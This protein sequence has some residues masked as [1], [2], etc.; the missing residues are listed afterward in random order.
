MLLAD[1]VIAPSCEW[2]SLLNKIVSEEHIL[3]LRNCINTKKYLF[4][5]QKPPDLKV[6]NVLFIGSV[7]PRKGAFDLIKAID[8]LKAEQ[9]D[10]HAWFV[11][12]EQREGDLK[13]AESCLDDLKIK[14]KCELLGTVIGE[15]KLQLLSEADIFVLPTYTEGLPLAIGEALAA[16]LPIIST[17]VGGIPEVI[18]DGYNG[19]LIQPGDLHGLSKRIDTLAKNRQLRELMGQRGKKIAEQ[20]LDVDNFVYHLL[21]LY[22]DLLS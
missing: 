7:G 17:P 21:G 14:E 19:F 15:K 3:T 22:H 8:L 1:K 10:L 5:A 16:G 2:K 6:I 9:Y 4:S 13:Q 12:F 20:K 11:G 18:E